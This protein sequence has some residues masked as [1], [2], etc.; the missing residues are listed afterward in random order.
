MTHSV[1]FLGDQFVDQ[2][3]VDVGQ[4]ETPPLKSLRQLGVVESEQAQQR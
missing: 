2:I 4:P 1:V 3:A